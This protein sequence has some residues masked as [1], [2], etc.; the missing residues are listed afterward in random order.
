MMGVVSVACA[1]WLS[2]D[3]ILCCVLLVYVKNGSFN[4]KISCKDECCCST[5][6]STLPH[7]IMVSIV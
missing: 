3:V 2:G 6:L 7:C 4:H 5:N 1:S